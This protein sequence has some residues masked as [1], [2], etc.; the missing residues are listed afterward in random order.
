MISVNS[1][2]RAAGD[3]VMSS[4]PEPRMSANQPAVRKRV[5]WGFLVWTAPLAY[6]FWAPYQQ[7]AA[8]FEWT[9]T[10]L[11][12]AAVLA[13]FLAGITYP[14]DR[15]FVARICVALLLIAVGFLAYRPSGGIYFPVVATF[16]PPVLGGSMGLSITIVSA[17]AIL[18]GVEWG[19]LYLDGSQGPYFPLFVVA[20][21]FISGIGVVFIARQT[22]DIQRRDKASERERIANDL[23]DVLGH[24]LSSLALKAELARR[25]FHTDP[26]RAL[27]EISD[28]ERIARQ[29]I[30]DMRA[31]IQGYHSG[32]IYVELD[33][34]TSLLKA[35]DVSVERRCED[36]DMSPAT[37]RVLA[38]IV[39]E[40]VTN[41][42]RHSRA[43]A[44][45]LA[46]FRAAGAY[47]L[48]ISDDGCGGE[49]AEG[50]GMRSI[51]ARAEA[52]GG[53]AVWS[54]AIGTQLS[55]SLPIPAMESG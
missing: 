32:D 26:A 51:R 49:H 3:K 41:I 35:A 38:L 30:E 39:R 33:R 17:L 18:F 12:L 1:S 13:L 47:Q 42:L 6:V 8:W 48:E 36:L 34:M 28:V 55:V 19:L 2:W 16:L 54:S 52:L 43:R 23:H 40:A 11:T 22:R 44:C 53:T 29:G 20:Q 24:S 27:L 21:I 4:I 45:Q 31:A 9:A 14:E 10:T 5:P 25:V 46:L 7:H 50:I 15:R 37:Q